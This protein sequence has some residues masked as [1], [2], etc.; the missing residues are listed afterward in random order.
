[1][2]GLIT[3]KRP[4][5]RSLSIGMGSTFFGVLLLALAREYW[6]L[7]TGAMLIGIGSAVFH[8]KARAWR[9]SPRGRFGTAQSL[10]QLAGISARR[11][12]RFCPF[13]VV[14]LGRPSV[15]DLFGCGD[16]GPAILWRVGTWAEGGAA[17]G[18]KTAGPSPFRGRRVAWAIVVLAL[19]T[20]TR[21]STRPVSPA[22]TVL[23]DREVRADHPAG[24]VDA[25]PVSGRH[26]GA[27]CWA[28]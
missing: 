6:V 12:G 8:P 20:F 2:V 22:I 25:V 5:P 3:D 23:P 10:F 1:M 21:T 24:A 28:G 15:A 17:P 9:A 11:W 27:S 7:L 18:R 19:L 4:M 16:A 14:P 13:I 26:G